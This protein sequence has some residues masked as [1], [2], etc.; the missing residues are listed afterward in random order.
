[1]TTAANRGLR[2][3]MA[4]ADRIGMNNSN[5]TPKTNSP[6]IWQI[7]TL[8]LLALVGS[9]HATWAQEA[10]P[11]DQTPPPVVQPKSPDLATDGATLPDVTVETADQPAAKPA[12]AQPKAKS[13]AEIEGAPAPVKAKR[14][15]KKVSEAPKP[16]PAASA[17]LPQEAYE[18]AEPSTSD[19]ST[20]SDVGSADPLGGPSGIN[21]YTAK[22]TTTATK[23]ETPIKDIPQSI[24]VVTKEQAADQGS[25]GLGQALVY[26]P[27]VNVA[28][29]EGHRD[30]VTIRG[31]Q[32][33]A[34][35]FVNGVRDDTEYYRDLYNVE[36]I[37]VLKGPS[38]MVFGRGGGG[39]VVNRSTKSADGRTVRDATV[40]SGMYDTKRAAIDV[41]QAI[42]SAAA[43]RLN[44][45]YEDSGNFRD[46]F[47]ME[48]LG[49]SPT[50]GFKLTDSTKLLVS[51]EYYNDERTVDR[52]V[53]SRKGHPSEGR[54]ESFF[55]NP[56]VN[57]AAFEGHT[58]SAT[59]E[60]R[61]DGNLKVRNHSSFTDADKVYANT[62]ADGS[63]SEAGDV[64]IGG[65]RD[66][67]LRQSFINQTDVTYK[68]QVAPFIRHT[69][70]VGAEFGHQETENNRDNP[71]FGTPAGGS[72][73]TVPFANSAFFKI[74]RASCRERV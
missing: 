71:N 46:F 5:H 13:V 21:G 41:G 59:L 50:M 20:A 39:G 53:P 44:A 25:K 37:E 22:K 29:G 4:G 48:R 24:S 36:A 2:T 12:P 17:P 69:I 64:K 28:L 65:Y 73:I 72:S 58:A 32:T 74:G 43:F 45:M 47:E 40:T 23:T 33:T 66:E 30:A 42:S 61:F 35:F 1:M 16:K 26:V 56:E 7:S 63:V 10:A 15:K 9:L 70:L 19:T 57:A 6:K 18:S 52:G 60:H 67:T 3:A 55:G 14:A 31:Q 51:Y 34:D 68:I 11:A 49:I 54:I 62:F 38:A 8:A 27:G